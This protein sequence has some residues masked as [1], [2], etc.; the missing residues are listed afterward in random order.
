MR[1][2]IICHRQGGMQ[3]IQIL[4]ELNGEFDHHLTL[5]NPRTGK[6]EARD[7]II[8]PLQGTSRRV[9][10]LQVAYASALAAGGMARLVPSHWTLL[11]RLRTIPDTVEDFVGYHIAAD[12]LGGD[13]LGFGSINNYKPSGSA[14]VR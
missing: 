4:H 14:K 1:P 5:W 2:M 10:G 7:L 3:T 6:P 12:L 11:G 13:L 9:A 8:D